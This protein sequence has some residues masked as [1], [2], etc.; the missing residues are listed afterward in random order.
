[1]KRAIITIKYKLPPS[2]KGFNVY[3]FMPK[4]LLGSGISTSSGLNFIPSKESIIFLEYLYVS[5]SK[6]G[7]SGLTDGSIGGL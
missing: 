1:M 3:D 4:R 6:V 7:F 2:E 5:S